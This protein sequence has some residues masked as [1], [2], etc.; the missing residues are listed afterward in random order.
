MVQTEE[1]GNSYRSLMA[2]SDMELGLGQNSVRKEFD[3]LNS[4]EDR[5]AALHRIWR[6]CQP[7]FDLVCVELRNTD[8]NAIPL[9]GHLDGL[10]EH[11]HRFHFLL[12]LLKRKFNVIPDFDL[13]TK[14]CAGHYSS[15]ALDLKAMINGKLEML[16]FCEVPIRQINMNQYGV[17]QIFQ[18]V[19]CASWGLG[20]LF[21]GF[22]ILLRSCSY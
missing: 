16:I 19:S 15:L 3:F 2:E 14:N 5:M 9:F 22:S 6:T 11:L 17:Y 8:P 12:N 10:S 21:L 1:M 7:S 18:A 13:A 20:F 4:R